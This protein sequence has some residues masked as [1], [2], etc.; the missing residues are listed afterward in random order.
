MSA[1][2]FGQY[3]P[4]TH[5]IAHIS[6][7]HFLGA[8]S[9]GAPRSLHGTVDTDRT[10]RLA[11]EQLER[12]GL[13]PDA[14]VF[15]GDIADRGEPDAYRRV[16]DLV[17]AIAARLGSELVWVMGNHDER[18][19]FRTELLRERGSAGPVD[20]V[21]DIRGL[22][23]VALDTSVPGYHH[24]DLTDRQLEWLAGVLSTPAEHGTVLALHHP[25]IPT[26]LAL[27]N[28]LELRR[29]ERLADVIAGSDIRG[30][31]GGHLH[32]ATHS[33]FAGIPVSVAAATCYTMDL[34][35]PER[36]LVG[37]D[38]GQAINLVHIHD[39]QLVHSVVPLG[40]FPTVSRFDS[41]FLDRMQSLNATDR[42]E[43]FSRKP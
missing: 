38:G 11:M 28:L 5:L 35:A 8:G 31:L 41:A 9:D 36:E 19:A 4:A 30:I 40:Q 12:S 26:P 37:M 17:E 7:T 22:R 15:T 24:G 39:T 20:R 18:A 21:F 25:P 27:M 14:F 6:D 32:Y 43:A 10:V 1:V 42:T 2:Q 33:L 13:R 34:S 29:Q 3:P 23:I 16:R